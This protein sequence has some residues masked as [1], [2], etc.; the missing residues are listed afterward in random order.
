MLAWAQIATVVCTLA[1]VWQ[2]VQHRRVPNAL[3]LLVVALAVVLLA[4]GQP[5]WPGLTWF[6]AMLAAVVG[7][8]VFGWFYARGLMGAGDVKFFAAS[9]LLVGPFGLCLVWLVA[10]LLGGLHAVAIHLRGRAGRPARA[11]GV[12]YAAYMAAGILLVL[13]LRSGIEAMRGLP[14]YS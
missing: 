3:V 12:P 8:I 5:V 10:S 6:S 14:P 2:D 7:L 9:G 1:A 11:R 13:S 4:S